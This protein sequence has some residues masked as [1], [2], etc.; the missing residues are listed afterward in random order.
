MY[1]GGGT[2]QRYN[3]G[4]G[5][6]DLRLD[7]DNLAI[8]KPI[9]I[10]FACF[11]DKNITSM[12]PEI[13]LLGDLNLTT[14]NH[15]RARERDDYFLYLEDY[16]FFDDHI[17]LIKNLKEQYPDDVI[18]VAGSLAFSSLVHKELLDEIL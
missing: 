1:N 10:V 13:A 2:R 9:H 3:G 4:G 7:I 8:G 12:L 15:P 11:K 16:K 18:L 5:A 14:F 6:T 17:A